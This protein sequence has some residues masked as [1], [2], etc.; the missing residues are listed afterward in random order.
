[1]NVYKNVTRLILFFRGA[2]GSAKLVFLF[3]SHSCSLSLSLCQIP[4]LPF[5]SLSSLSSLSLCLSEG[6]DRLVFLA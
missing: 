2:E 5:H 1:M 4:C 3:S 6:L